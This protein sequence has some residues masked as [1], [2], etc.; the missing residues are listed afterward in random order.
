[1]KKCLII[2]GAILVLIGLLIAG[3]TSRTPES[4]PD[5]ALVK[6]VQPFSR[7]LLEVGTSTPN[8]EVRRYSLH[9]SFDDAV[10]DLE[11]ELGDKHWTKNVTYAKASFES[12]SHELVEVDRGRLIELPP[13]TDLVNG[14]DDDRFPLVDYMNPPQ[15][16]GWVMVTTNRKLSLVQAAR[17]AMQKRF[18]K[19]EILNQRSYELVCT[20]PVMGSV[21]QPVDV[22][23][24]SDELQ[25]KGHNFSFFVAPAVAA[26]K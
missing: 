3:A 2:I 16:I 11:K 21:N 13:G 4:V 15:S 19:R 12:S 25:G 22:D 9:F 24:G 23:K 17:Q 5:V 18:G 14:F 1:M 10:K 7:D 8:F 20:N 6:A 26:D